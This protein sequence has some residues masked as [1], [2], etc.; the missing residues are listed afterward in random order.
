[1][2]QMKAAFALNESERIA[3]LRDLGILDTPPESLF[4][5]LTRLAAFVCN[6]PVALISLV[7][8]ERQWFKSKIGTAVCE[9][10]RDQAFCAHAISNPSEIFLVPDASLDPR[11]SDNPLVTGEMKLRSY[12]GAPLV[13]TDGFAIGTLCVID[14]IPRRLSAE[15]KESLRALARQAVSQIE[16]RPNRIT[17]QQS[18]LADDRAKTALLEC[19]ELEHRLTQ[20]AAGSPGVICSFRLRPDGSCCMPYAS[21]SIANIYGIK[22]E[23]LKDDASDLFRLLHPDDLKR[24]NDSIRESARTMRPWREEFRVLNPFRGQLWVEGHS[25]PEREASGSTIWHGV[26]TDITKRVK[27]QQQLIESE[28]RFRTLMDNAPDAAYI[29]TN[30]CFAYVNRALMKLLGAESPSQLLGRP[31]LEVIGPEFQSI[32]KERIRILNE[33]RASVPTRELQ[34]IRFDGKLVDV[35]ISAVPIDF[36]GER[37]ALAFARDITRRKQQEAEL[38]KAKQYADTVSS[39]KSQFLATVSHEIRTPMNGVIGMANLLLE[40]NLSSEQ[41]HYTEILRDSGNDILVIINDILDFSKI[42]AGKLAIE[43][44]PFDLHRAIKEVSD[45]LAAKA[46]K[47]KIELRL[48]VAET[49]PKRVIGD[50]VRVRQIL[51]N[52]ADN[53]IKFTAQGQV[54]IDVSCIENSADAVRVKFAVSDTGIGI[55]LEK[56]GRLFQKF[57]QAETSTTRR[58]GGTGLGLAICKQ[59]VELM[60][61]QIGVRS[62]PGKGSSFWCELP[63]PIDRESEVSSDQSSQKDETT[64]MYPALAVLLAEDNP[65]SQLVATSMLERLGCKVD[66]AATGAEAVA[67]V[68]KKKYNLVFMDCHMPEMDG[69]EAARKIRA[70]ET[71]GKHLPII[72]FTAGALAVDREKFTEAGM[73][74]YVL[75]PVNKKILE[76]TLRRW[77]RDL[78]GDQIINVAD[79]SETTRVVTR[80]PSAFDEVEALRFVDGDRL[81]LAQMAATFCESAPQLQHQLQ[82]GITR[83]DINAAT[84]AAHTLKGSAR[85]LA[86]P[87]IIAAAR[88]AEDAARNCDWPRIESASHDLEAELSRLIPELKKIAVI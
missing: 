33:E 35:E 30:R 44:L 76:K 46:Q 56:Q 62:E 21:P 80:T 77:V 42:E 52:L 29:Q 40:T 71:D 73:D 25:V 39:A 88:D 3:R 78:P 13:T 60:G 12:A 75:K 66:I 85:M 74:D 41:R 32:V 81:L 48:Q 24:V 16:S 1:M 82:D 45:L 65:T 54:A 57:S 4:D 58:F 83:R 14:F 18:I 22:S 69:I 64:I 70:S 23:S 63:F 67:M 9:T 84:I 31:I 6:T 59:L 53:A 19:A 11:F 26:L 27:D 86:A 72:A 8:E 43:P 47:K 38:Q 68:V 37:G 55:P 5:D 2:L 51:L 50:R 36:H 28:A 34:L 7:D 87:A 20:I 17:S 15:Q 10:H 79:K 61:G 49:T